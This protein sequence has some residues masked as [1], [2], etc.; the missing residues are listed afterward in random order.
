MAG[1]HAEGGSER[2]ILVNLL[3]S[4]KSHLRCMAGAAGDIRNIADNERPQ[5]TAIIP[6]PGIAAKRGYGKCFP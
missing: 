3:I 1:G 5:K 6:V 4:T 2:E